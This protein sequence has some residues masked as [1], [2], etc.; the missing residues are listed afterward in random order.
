MRAFARVLAVDAERADDLV[1]MTLARAVAGGLSVPSSN[2]LQGWMFTIMHI[3]HYG[4]AQGQHHARLVPTIRAARGPKLPANDDTREMADFNR[5][6]WRLLDEQREVLML[7]VAS[8]LS[9]WEIASVYGASPAR[10]QARVRLAR[11]K[12]LQISYGDAAAEIAGVMPPDAIRRLLDARGVVPS[13]A[14]A[15]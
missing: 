2:T 6:F 3:L 14:N 15:I 7:D 12:L 9:A 1:A 10:F 5:A 4:D 13:P 11:Q 8:D